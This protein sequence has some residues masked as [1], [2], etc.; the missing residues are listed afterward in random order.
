MSVIELLYYNMLILLFFKMNKYKAL[1]SEDN[2]L[3]TGLVG[4]NDVYVRDDLEDLGLGLLFS[5]NKTGT[6]S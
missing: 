2:L 5:E 3:V 1:F 4:W 6:T